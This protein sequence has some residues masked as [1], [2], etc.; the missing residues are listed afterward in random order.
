MYFEERKQTNQLKIEFA[1]I[2]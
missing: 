1:K 2:N